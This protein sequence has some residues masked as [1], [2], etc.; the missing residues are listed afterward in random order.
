VGEPKDPPPREPKDA[1]ERKEP[2]PPFRPRLDLI[3][4]MDG[5]GRGIVPE[6]GRWR[7]LR[8]SKPQA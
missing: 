3:V 5:D 8:P 7:H 1:G 2:P 6:R 4:Y